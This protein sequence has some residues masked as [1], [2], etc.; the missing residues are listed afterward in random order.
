MI[1]FRH[2]WRDSNRDAVPRK[3]KWIESLGLLDPVSEQAKPLIEDRSRYMPRIEKALTEMT[4]VV[5][6]TNGV[7]RIA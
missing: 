4:A 7:P 1:G 6:L 5:I 3:P 2:L